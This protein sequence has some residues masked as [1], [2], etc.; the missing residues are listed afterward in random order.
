MI[1]VEKMKRKRPSSS[2]RIYDEECIFSGKEKYVRSTNS[3][4]KLVKATQLRVDQTLRERAIRKCDEKILAITSRDIVAAE[5]CYH[6]SCYRDYTRPDK[7]VQDGKV[8]K[9]YD[10]EEDAFSALFHFIRAHFIDKMLVVPMTDLT[11]KVESFV[12][13]RGIEM[14]SESTKKHMKRKIEAE[15]GSALEIFPGD[16]GKLLVMSDN[17]SRQDCVKANVLLQKEVETLESK[18]SDAMKVIDQ[19]AA[20]IRRSILD[21]KWETP[22]P[23]HPS[24][25][26]AESFPIPKYLSRFLM[27]IITSDPGNNNPS[28]RAKTLVESIF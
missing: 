23:I 15:F 22:W 28:Q 14:L 19:S 7:Q 27:G 1:L 4:E 18:S 3:R 10:P 11:K 16:K 9:E 17:L 12:Q 25:L 5:A 21:L 13:S 8:A 26:R 2:F 20:H 6:R 24:D